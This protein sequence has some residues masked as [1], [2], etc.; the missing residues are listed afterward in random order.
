MQ[1]PKQG[2]SNNIPKVSPSFLPSISPWVLAGIL[3]R[4]YL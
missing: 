4:G 1:N 3:S 2:S